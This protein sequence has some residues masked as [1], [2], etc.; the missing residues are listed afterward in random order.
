MGVMS[1]LNL[2]NHHQ[3]EDFEH[4]HCAPDSL[5]HGYHS[6]HQCNSPA[7]D[8]RLLKI[9]ERVLLGH[10]KKFYV[11]GCEINP[12]PMKRLTALK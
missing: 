10:E 12:L 8:Q 2:L 1:E 5:A 9:S 11:V 6:L 4:H 3:A 7:H